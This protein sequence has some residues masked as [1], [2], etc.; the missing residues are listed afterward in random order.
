VTTNVVPFD[1]CAP[2]TA[3]KRVVVP[4]DQVPPP[5]PTEP[6]SLGKPAAEKTLKPVDIEQL[7]VPG[8]APDEPFENE[9]TYDLAVSTDV[10]VTF[11]DTV[12]TPRWTNLIPPPADA[13]GNTD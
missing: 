1:K 6:P 12:A 8:A 4:P 5:I 10:I 2:L 7:P 3:V 13:A 11:P 9:L